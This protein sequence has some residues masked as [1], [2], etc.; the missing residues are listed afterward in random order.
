M[1]R[2]LET[3]DVWY[4]PCS[5]PGRDCLPGDAAGSRLVG[6]RD[7]KIR[8]AWRSFLGAYQLILASL[9][10]Q[11][12]EQASADQWWPGLGW[13]C[14]ETAQHL[15]VYPIYFDANNGMPASRTGFYVPM[16]DGWESTDREI[17]VLSCD[18]S[19]GP[20]VNISRVGLRLP[21]ARGA[22]GAGAYSK[23]SLRL[24]GEEHA[25]F[26]IGCS[27]STLLKIDQNLARICNLALPEN[28]CRFLR[29]Q[30]VLV[31]NAMGQFEERQK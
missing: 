3:E 24:N 11:V 27:A 22:C 25:R 1:A 26:T 13:S 2:C 23:Y 7:L 10:M 28:P 29:G 5:E 15:A 12:P 8:A 19:P 17:P 6:R 18:L 21:S 9:V 31:L 30:N 14:D 16:A 20:V 4:D